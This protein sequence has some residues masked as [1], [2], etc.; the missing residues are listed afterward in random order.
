MQISDM[1]PYIAKLA[2]AAGA[3]VSLRFMKGSWFSRLCA[4]VCGVLLSIYLAPYI[5]VKTGIPNELAGF[6]TGMLGLAIVSRFF[7]WI[8]NATVFEQLWQIVIDALKRLMGK[9]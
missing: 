8:S 5:Q 2:G 9:S 6:L 4:F 7:D 3:L 1:D